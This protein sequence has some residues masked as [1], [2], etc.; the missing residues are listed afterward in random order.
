MNKIPPTPRE[1]D[2]YEQMK[3]PRAMREYH[4]KLSEIDNLEREQLWREGPD[5]GPYAWRYDGS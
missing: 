5:L 4:N 2:W 1:P 3:N